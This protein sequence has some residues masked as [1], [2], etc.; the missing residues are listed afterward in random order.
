MVDSFWNT[1]CLY[2]VL[3][4]EGV[5]LDFQICCNGIP[6]MDTGKSDRVSPFG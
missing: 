2:T 6:F 5:E 3:N 4:R 1:S